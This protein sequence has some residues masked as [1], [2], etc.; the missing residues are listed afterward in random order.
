MW[1]EYLVFLQN[2]GGIGTG[3]DGCRKPRK[4]G[5]QGENH[6]FL[7]KPPRFITLYV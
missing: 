1:T 2:L 7:I 6:V 3:G 4:M 5:V